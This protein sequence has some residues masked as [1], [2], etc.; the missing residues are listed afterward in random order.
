VASEYE[1][2]T[3]SRTVFFRSPWARL[4]WGAVSL[5]LLAA[6]LFLIRPL[7]SDKPAPIHSWGLVVGTASK[8][9]P[10]W[11]GFSTFLRMYNTAKH[12]CEAPVRAEG[13][14]EWA[15]GIHA[16]Y[17]YGQLAPERVAFGVAGVRVVGGEVHAPGDPGWVELKIRHVDPGPYESTL[18]YSP[19][20]PPFPYHIPPGSVGTGPGTIRFRL[21]VDGAQS[22]GYGSCELANPVLIEHPGE[23]TSARE[24]VFDLEI[25][26]LPGEVAHERVINE[27]IVWSSVPGKRPD[28]STIGSN[29]QVRNGRVLIGCTEGIGGG[30]FKEPTNIYEGQ[31]AFYERSTCGG[32]NRFE[33][34][35]SEDVLTRNAFFGGILIS[36]AL[37]LL[38]EVAVTGA[39]GRRKPRGSSPLGSPPD[40][41]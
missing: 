20:L 23:E 19:L 25:H 2:Q 6:G 3:A 26:R 18:L 9:N 29:A 39:T 30:S 32:V 7:L 14:L 28:P 4:A 31:R 10:G 40:R 37:G 36:A 11:K 17:S 24:G 1:F 35:G 5:V 22:S 16:R 8:R 15:P 41:E 38:L 33:A 12:G 34:L 27:A 21:Y 13:V